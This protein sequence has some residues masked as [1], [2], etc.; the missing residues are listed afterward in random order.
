MQHHLFN[1]IFASVLNRD[2]K[3]STLKKDA[4]LTQNLIHNWQICY[5]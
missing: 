5:S 3:C 1:V 2:K 4:N